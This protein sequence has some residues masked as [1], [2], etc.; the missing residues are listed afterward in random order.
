M[1]HYREL[2]ARGVFEQTAGAVAANT[3]S[4]WKNSARL[5]HVAFPIRYFDELGIPRL[6]T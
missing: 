3:H 5:I 1:G 4:W 2:R 6:V